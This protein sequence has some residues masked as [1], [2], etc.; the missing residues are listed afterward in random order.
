[1]RRDLRSPRWW[2]SICALPIIMQPLILFA[3]E[4][5]ARLSFQ[6]TALAGEG[7]RTYTIKKGDTISHIVRQMG[8]AAPSYDTLK[9]LNPHIP[10]LN[11]IYPGQMLTLAH[12]AGKEKEGSVLPETRNYT[13]RKGDSITRIIRSEL[14]A[15]PGDV[16]NLLQ[17]L[18]L[19]NPGIENINKIYPGQMLKLPRS[20]KTIAEKDLARKA[21]PVPAAA[22]FSEQDKAPS[23]LPVNLPMESTLAILKHIVGQLK[24]TLMTSGNYYIPLPEAGQVTIDCTTIPVVELDDGTAVLLDFSQRLPNELT[25]LIRANWQNYQ[26]IKIESSDNIAS[27]LHKII[28]SSKSYTITKVQKPILLEDEPQVLLSPDW[29]I[30]KKGPSDQPLSQLGLF[31]DVDRSQLLPR[32]I[33]E[34]A[35]KKGIDICEILADKIQPGRLDTPAK[36]PGMPR[37]TGGNH[38]ELLQ[39][40]FT[41]LGLEFLRNREI[42]IFDSAKDGFN[43]S[44]KAEWLVKKGSKNIL[45]HKNKLPQQ[46][47]DILRS[48][49]MEPLYLDQGLSKKSLLAGVLSPLDVPSQ[50]ALFSVPESR[51]KDKFALTFPALKIDSGQGPVY[52]IEFDMAEDIYEFLADNWK[53]GIIRY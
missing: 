4:G 2:A 26:A 33:R 23:S 35:K 32:L 6:K 51:R 44:I 31:F 27:I 50:F 48:E 24:G 12:E 47:I 10:D 15:K 39:N 52:L 28:G 8:T 9:S 49:G 20:S 53:L 3:A 25:R 36:A 14:G 11:M 7:A 46:F 37:I 17:Q 29:L 42:K 43:L 13:A 16:A 21:A 41:F 5:T 1:M 45:I 18:K 22:A 38:D 34:R 30:V 19:L 40:F